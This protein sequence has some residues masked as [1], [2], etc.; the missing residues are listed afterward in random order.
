M[1]GCG[2]DRSVCNGGGIS[3]GHQTFPNALAYQTLRLVASVLLFALSLFFFFSLLISLSVRLSVC[4]ISCLSVCLSNCLSVFVS[5]SYYT[6]SPL[7][8][9]RR[10]PSVRLSSKFII[11]FFFS[12]FFSPFFFYLI[13]IYNIILILPSQHRQDISTFKRRKPVRTNFFFAPP[14]TR[15]PRVRV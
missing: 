12:N 11:F 4:L 8:I 10:F 15:R 2:G 1:E 9:H 3:A 5:L 14:K 7:S 6:K 13:Y